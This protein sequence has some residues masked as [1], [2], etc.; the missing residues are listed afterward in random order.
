MAVPISGALFA[1]TGPQQPTGSTGGEG[2]QTDLERD[3]RTASPQ[4]LAVKNEIA[5]GPKAT[6]S[7]QTH[8]NNNL[9]PGW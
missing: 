9:F 6:G 5:G 2:S 3:R 4:C 1:L 8:I 7:E